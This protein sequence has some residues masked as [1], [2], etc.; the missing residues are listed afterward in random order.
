MPAPQSAQCNVSA[1]QAIVPAEDRAQRLAPQNNL[2]G[3]RRTSKEPHLRKRLSQ[4]LICPHEW[5]CTTRLERLSCWT[6]T[7][8]PVERRANIRRQSHVRRWPQF[9]SRLRLRQPYG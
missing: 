7:L 3:F 1:P 9:M 5:P 4:F 2:R 6:L 8:A